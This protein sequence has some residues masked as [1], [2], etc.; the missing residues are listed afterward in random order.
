MKILSKLF[1]KKEPQNEIED[2]VLIEAGV[3]SNCWGTMEYDNQ[4]VDFVKDQTKSNINKNKTHKKAFIQ[5]FVETYVTGIHLKREGEN[6]YC[7]KCNSKH[8]I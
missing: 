6:L 1:E 2:S 3:C 8:S 7:A 5:Q 4:F